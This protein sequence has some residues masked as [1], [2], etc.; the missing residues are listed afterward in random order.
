MSKRARIIEFQKRSVPAIDPAKPAA[1]Q[2][3]STL[4]ATILEMD[5]EPGQIISENELGNLFGASRTPVREAFSNLRNQGL[6]TTYPNRGSYVSKLS[7]AHIKGAQFVREVI[8]IAVVETLCRRELASD[9][10]NEIEDNLQAQQRAM[11]V[12]DGP[13]FHRLDDAFHLVLAGAIN[14]PRLSN[15][16]HKEKAILDRLRILSLSYSDH[17]ANLFDDHS[18]IFDAILAGD[19][20][21]AKARVSTHLRRIKGTLSDLVDAHPDYFE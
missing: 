3:T 8:E 11:T 19:A 14:L 9:V 5:L 16:I 13:E 10:R 18:G 20:T 6:V 12:C 4:R 1:A 21:A 2:I 7:V 17:L 15:I